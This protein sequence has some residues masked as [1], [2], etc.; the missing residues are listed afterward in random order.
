MKKSDLNLTNLPE[1]F[2]KDNGCDLVTNLDFTLN[3]LTSWSSV[4][5][6]DDD[7][8]SDDNW[9][10]KMETLLVPECNKRIPPWFKADT[11]EFISILKKLDDETDFKIIF[12]DWDDGTEFCVKPVA[13]NNRWT[14]FEKSKEQILT[15][16]VEET[17][18]EEE[19]TN[20]NKVLNA[21]V[22][23][24]LNDDIDEL[25]CL[26]KKLDDINAKGESDNTALHFATMC[27][28]FIDDACKLLIELG[29]DI[30][31]KNDAGNTPLHLTAMSGNN[32]GIKL[33]VELGADVT[34]QN[35]ENLTALDCL[36]IFNDDCDEDIVNLLENGSK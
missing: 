2:A 25:K 1:S 24:S 33:L 13:H 5:E 3:I 16:A 18:E 26:Y 12:T 28:Y 8:D 23:A 27:N 10:G 32:F 30:N 15:D 9:V 22:N 35:D 4:D 7:F 20:V 31:A 17:V 14:Y 21:I 11:E 19:D 6:Q 34:I 29:A 36:Q